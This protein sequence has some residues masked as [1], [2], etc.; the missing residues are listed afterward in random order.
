MGSSIGRAGR[1]TPPVPMDLVRAAIRAHARRHDELFDEIIAALLTAPRE[2]LA[3]ELTACLGCQV[4]GRWDRGWQPADLHRVIA[5]QLGATEAALLAGAVVA[6]SSNY[7]SLGD[8][9]APR[10]MDQVDAVAGGTVHHVPDGGAPWVDHLLATIGLLHA[11][12]QLPDLPLL[13]PPPSAWHRGMRTTTD[14][15]P[16]DHEL[17]EVRALLAQA[18]SD[19]DDAEVLTAEAQVLLARH[20]FDRALRTVDGSVPAQE[21]VARRVAVDDPYA[22]AKASLLA[23]VCV[24]NGA[25]AVWTEEAGFTTV[26]GHPADI[27]VVDALFVSLLF[28]SARALRR[29]G[30]KRDRF[31]RSRTTRFR[32]AFL[33][34]SAQRV[35]SRLRAV[36]DATLDA[37]GRSGRLRPVLAERDAAVERAVAAV[38]PDV[39]DATLRAEAREEWVAPTLFDDV[40]DACLGDLL[41]RRSAS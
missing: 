29:E 14:V 5:R 19:D 35:A 40:D 24:A 8:E 37:D 31:G 10:W 27:D 9:V 15:E 41:E 6:E 23:G 32:R 30:S 16:S 18:E 1:A 34:T 26:F 2:P 7:R 22:D 20:R 4:A 11:L 17:D 28:Q 21:V 25:R 13:E 3:T 33:Q 12:E 39:I 36:V 38:F